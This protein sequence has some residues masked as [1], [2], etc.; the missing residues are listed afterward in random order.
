ME[1]TH[2]Y[3]TS[4]MKDT[5]S[6][7]IAV[8]DGHGGSQT[9]RWCA[10]NFHKLL[11]TNIEKYSSSLQMPTIIDHTFQQAD[12]AIQNNAKADDKSGS[13]V[14]MAYIKTD[15]NAQQHLYTANVGD[16]RIVLCSNYGVAYRLTYDHSAED[17]REKSRIIRSG[18]D[19]LLGRV[20]GVLAITRALGD[21]SLKDLVSCRPFITEA[22][23]DAEKDEF[24][25]LACDGLWDVFSDQEAVDRI[26]NIKD[27]NQAAK[28]LVNDAIG[29]GSMDN[30]TCLVARLNSI[31]RKTST[32]ASTLSLFKHKRSSSSIAR[33]TNTPDPSDPNAL[34]LSPLSPVE[35][36]FSFSSPF[37]STTRFKHTDMATLGCGVRRPPSPP[38][39]PTK[40]RRFSDTADI[41]SLRT[42][43]SKLKL[44]TGRGFRYGVP[45]VE[46]PL[47]FDSDDEDA[48]EDDG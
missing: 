20:A 1:D 43:M 33:S 37:G 2:N 9:A 18:G 13:T 8:F 15:A 48:I 10:D 38:M 23:I 34:I 44:Q 29:R 7:Y 42:E 46:R 45:R 5:T 14:A 39:N 47:I 35:S 22:T 4:F 12:Y 28:I 21:G 6:T 30:I 24:L 19:I 17:P 41:D 32:T 16:S 3:D 40:Q 11:A 36:G 27:P 31:S 26:R 25:I